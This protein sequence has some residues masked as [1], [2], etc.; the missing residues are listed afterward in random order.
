MLRRSLY[1]G[2]ITLNLVIPDARRAPAGRDPTTA[3]RRA[4]PSLPG[5]LGQIE[6]ICLGLLLEDFGRC[7][8][9]SKPTH[10][11]PSPSVS[12][13][14]GARRLPVPGLGRSLP[15][16]G[17]VLA[18]FRLQSAAQVRATPRV[19]TPRARFSFEPDSDSSTR[20]AQIPFARLLT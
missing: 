9:L 5:T 12:R 4:R 15:L 18:V 16:R 8:L 17:R 1:V 13:A 20:F 14:H 2:M 7:T 6:R 3:R 11:A 19:P 10:T